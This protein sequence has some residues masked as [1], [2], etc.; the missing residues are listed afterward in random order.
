[1]LPSSREELQIL[2]AELGNQAGIVG[3][4]KL[5]WDS[6]GAETTSAAAVDPVDVQAAIALSQFKAGFLA[7]TS[8]E[9]RSP[10]N[11]VI[12][13]HQLILNGLTDDPEEEREFI[14]QA[15]GAARKMLA[16]MDD[17]IHVSKLENNTSPLDIQ[18]LCLADILAEIQQL[19][20]L[21][22]RNRN[23]KLEFLHPSDDPYVLADPTAL[24]QALLHLVDAP[25]A[26]MQEGFVRV[27]T[28]VLPANQQVQIWI[29][30]Q[31]PAD[32]WKEPIDL[33][34][35]EL[36]APAP[37]LP[38]LPL[39]TAQTLLTLLNSTLELVALPTQSSG[40]TR[41]QFTLP[42]VQESD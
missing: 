32:F 29:E 34:S 30:D 25:L 5:A 27:G 13:L 42:L 26:Q 6:L 36:P 11:S 8:H 16:L 21:Q 17:L 31:R 39:L 3:A 23:L 4:A 14:E 35:T 20:H 15:Y 1:V 37:P 40:V 38:G 28:E 33:L 19:T 9:L 10:I 41:L 18:P 2:V 7:R 24:K 22:A 12:G